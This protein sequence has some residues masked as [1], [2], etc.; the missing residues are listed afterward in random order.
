MVLTIID[1]FG[2][3]FRNFYALPPLKSKKGTPTGMITG[4]MNF[5]ASLGRDFPTDYVVFTLDSKEKETFRKEIFPE[6]KANRPEAPEDL[7][8]QLPIAID[9]IREMG[10]K[11]LEIPGF[12]SDDLIA[13]LATLAAKNGIKVK[14]VSHDK[15]MY[16]LIDDDKIIIFDPLKKKEIDE[17]GCIEK[18]GI[19]PKYFKDFQALVGDSSDNIPG[20]KGIG[21]KTAAKLI[22][23]YKTLENIYSHIDEIKG[24]LKKKLI[25]G[26][27]NAFLS[28]KLVTLKTDL[29]K[30]IN[31]DEFKYPQINP[32]LKVADKLIDLDIT[33][34]I[35]RVKKDGLYVKTKEP[36]NQVKFD[37][38][39]I[40]NEK[41]LFDTIDKIGEIVAFDTETT[42]L[43]NPKIVGFSFA[44]EAKKAYYVPI[45]HNYLGVS[46]QI[47]EK[48][49]L[50][51][52]EK[53]LQKKVIGHN[54]KFDFKMLKKYGIK[55][56]TPF[57][58]TM[59]MAWI[60]NPDSPV[61]LDSVAKRILGHK[62][63]KF[64]EI[65][66]KNQNFSEIDIHTAAKYAAEDAIITLKIYEKMKDKLWDEV[67]FDYENI[68]MPFINLLID[69]E[70]EGIKL[71]IE[72]MQKLQTQISQKLDE[73]NTKNL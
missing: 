9:L 55:T 38:I 34:I 29:F 61:G 66:G 41:E 19:H 37:A 8:T 23:E 20:V 26:K 48:S 31:L 67:K 57:A 40:E 35:E 64:K 39:L 17:K 45:N 59:I 24:A 69:M 56:P 62:N 65:V 2:F 33:S 30:N 68:E 21:V 47:P 58:D 49:A 50:K 14:I 7:K 52:I 73:I 18:F 16:Q 46:T 53:I 12:E 28:R 32:I 54:L 44:F 10:F 6:Y 63:I 42:S 51:A 3:L 13:S 27:E 11:M 72:Y 1:T 60:L 22:N 5:I 43:E 36:D 15:D 25:E 4:F 71:D 70:N